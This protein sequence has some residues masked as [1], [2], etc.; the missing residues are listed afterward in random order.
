[1]ALKT[2]L[3]SHLS[4]KSVK[5]QYSLAMLTKKGQEGT[6]T[7]VRG[8]PRDPQSEDMRCGEGWEAGAP[9][10]GWEGSRG[11]STAGKPKAPAPGLIKH[12]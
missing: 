10:A 7:K 4:S 9:T 5:M 1:M 11:G 12:T 8:L 6:Q 3:Q 2:S